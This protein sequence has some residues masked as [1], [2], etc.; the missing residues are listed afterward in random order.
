MQLKSQ[1]SVRKL[2]FL[3][4]IL[5]FFFKFQLE[6]PFITNKSKKNE[7]N[8]T[9]KSILKDDSLQSSLSKNLQEI[10]TTGLSNSY[11]SSFHSTL[12]NVESNDSRDSNKK[13]SRFEEKKQLFSFFDQNDQNLE[14]E[15]EDLDGETNL[16]LIEQLINDSIKDDSFSFVGGNGESKDKTSNVIFSQQTQLDKTND[17]EMEES[18]CFN[19]N[20]AND[21]VEEIEESFRKSF[22]LDEKTE[23]NFKENQTPTNTS[24]SEKM[25]DEEAEEDS[26]EDITNISTIYDQKNFNEKKIDVVELEDLNETKKEIVEKDQSDFYFKSNFVKEEDSFSIENDTTN[27]HLEISTNSRMISPNSFLVD[28]CSQK[29]PN[30]SNL[31]DHYSN[32]TKNGDFSFKNNFIS[33]QVTERSPLVNLSSNIT[34]QS[35][36]SPKKIDFEE[37]SSPFKIDYSPPPQT[38]FSSYNS[39]ILKMEKSLQHTENKTP[40]KETTLMDFKSPKNENSKKTEKSFLNENIFSTPNLKHILAKHLDT[41]NNVSADESPITKAINKFF[42]IEKEKK[43][44]NKKERKQK[45][46]KNSFKSN[47]ITFSPIKNNKEYSFISPYNSK[48]KTTPNK[49]QKQQRDDFC[50]QENKENHNNPIQNNFNQNDYFQIPSNRNPNF[51][52]HIYHININLPF[53]SSNHPPN[54]NNFWK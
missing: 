35:F 37:I 21:L 5:T 29:R 13:K 30:L 52:S 27:D 10:D 34:R 3:V 42:P 43:K 51:P 9:T 26:F 16:N 22:C 41:T 38:S 17:E 48:K 24:K 14:K 20:K 44:E 31:T 15:D 6:F 47:D 23:N 7:N 32:L 53:G 40:E 50:F 4:S 33:R 1:N 18:F 12:E 25:K 46:E 54:N 45:L 2:F 28:R 19:I 8:T 36:E 39:P 11:S 49:N